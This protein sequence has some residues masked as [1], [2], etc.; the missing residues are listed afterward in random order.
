MDKEI[1]LSALLLWSVTTS[2]FETTPT[3]TMYAT[4]GGALDS[5]AIYK[6]ENK[7][8]FIIFLLFVIVS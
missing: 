2:P 4:G 8:I 6:L 3:D 5:V 1:N 7:L